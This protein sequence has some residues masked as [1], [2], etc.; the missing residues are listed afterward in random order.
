MI[1]TFVSLT[2]VITPIS[3]ASHPSPNGHSKRREKG[4]LL[5][6]V[7]LDFLSNSPHTYPSLDKGL[8]PGE[9]DGVGATLRGG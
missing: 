8:G 9:M 1:I 5:F 6:A 2:S 3:T 7:F 4:P